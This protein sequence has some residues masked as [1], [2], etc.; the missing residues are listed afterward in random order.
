MNHT[1]ERRPLFGP[2]AFYKEVLAVALPVMAQQA[3]Q[4]LVSLIDNFM[5]A[6]LGDAKMAGVNVANQVNFVYMVVMMTLSAA[7]GIYMSQY[8][9]AKDEEG[10]RQAYRFKAIMTLGVSALYF[11]VC[12]VMPSSLVT[13]MTIGNAAQAEI[14]AHG[15]S[16]LRLVSWTFLPMALSQSIGSAFREIGRPNA[17]LVISVVATGVNTFFNWVMIYGNLGAPA[18]EIRGAA[19]ATII[20]RVVELAAFVTYARAVKAPFYVPL[21]GLLKAR[22]KLFREILG[23][24]S[25]ML[26]S[27]TSWVVSETVTTA[28]YNGRGGA[29]VVAGMS[30]GW[31]IA[32]IFFLVFTGIHVST[33]VVVGGLLGADRLDEARVKAR[34]IMSG[35]VV[36]G[37]VVA[38]LQVAS[39]AAVPIVFMN[40]TA[41]ATKVTAGLLVVIAVY[42]PLWSLLNSQFAVSRAGGD[43]MMGVVV[44]VG[45]TY[46]LFIP[47]AFALALLTPIGPVYMYAIV[48]LTDLVKWV[49]ACRWLKKERWLRNL[50]APA[51]GAAEKTV[52]NGAG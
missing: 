9:G 12:Q 28:L 1:L 38:L 43:T 51:D 47:G 19:I 20:A 15:A 45:V 48:K 13:M 34:W 50:A 14:V 31:A 26:L 16:Y 18:L 41:E 24:S 36:G 21:A 11:A 52:V 46:A 44:D 29:E 4:S 40:L 5:V 23:K 42:L 2:A 33:G 25:L 17:P 35:S 3:I 7:G 30:A 10:M 6:G 8:R 49:V 22:W 32:N 27:E 39:I 37:T